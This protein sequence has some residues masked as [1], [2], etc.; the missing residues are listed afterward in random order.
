MKNLSLL[1]LVVTFHAITSDKAPEPS[2]TPAWIERSNSNAQVLLDVMARF[3]PEYA[4]R[5][6]V[7]GLDEE[8][9][10]L[11][12]GV[13]ERTDAALQEAVRTLSV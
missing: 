12:Q 4:A 11:K 3:N 1:L 9:A 2:T 7:E 5:L 13:A 10:D 6:G 8:I